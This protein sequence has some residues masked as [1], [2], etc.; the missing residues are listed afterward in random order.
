MTA[1]LCGTE[2]GLGIRLDL[3]A[4][5]VARVEIRSSRPLGVARIFIGKPVA[6]VL[7]TLPLLYSVCATAQAAAAVGAAE[8]A[9]G[10]EPTSAQRRAREALV[11]AE[12]AR[13]HLLRCLLGWAPWL[14][15]PPDPLALALT[16]RLR[17]E[18]AQAL[19]PAGDGFVLGGGR[20]TPDRQRVAEVLALLDSVLA[21]SVLGLPAAAW[22]I[23]VRDGDG[24]DAWAAEGRSLGARLIA[25]VSDLGW[26]GLAAAPV[27]LLGETDAAELDRR[28]AGPDADAFIARPTWDGGPRETGALARVA[29]TPLIADL[30]ARQG[31]GLLT[32]LA[33][34]LVELAGLPGRLAEALAN[35]APA[36]PMA[37]PQIM[38]GSGIGQVEAA[39]GRLVHRVEIDAGQVRGYRILAPTEWNFHPDG[40]LAR[41]LLGL[42][43]GPELSALVGLLVEAVDPCVGYALELVDGEAP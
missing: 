2:G 28:L 36:T 23:Q 14:G 41:G 37:G 40:V 15:E 22:L 18:F 31:N 13:E 10:V 42:T 39:R 12:T 7:G 33:A 35:L 6:Q 24:L 8:A 20:L 3:A 43:A 26:S 30:M 19:Y 25:R 21:G 5:K 38:E 11:L 16:G 17:G 29:G 27:G 9:L 34:R 4:G 32:R 1:L